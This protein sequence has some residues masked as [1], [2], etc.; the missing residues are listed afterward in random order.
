MSD[1][2]LDDALDAPETSSAPVFALRSQYIKDLSFESP[3]APASLFTTREAPN[4]EVTVNLAAQRLEAQAVEL[5]F[6]INVRA[7]ADKNTLFLV[8]LVYAG[9]LEIRNIADEA[10]EE[11]IFVRGAQQLFPFA[12]RVVADL[13]RDSGFPP[14]MLETMDFDAM[15]AAQKNRSVH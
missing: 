14:V 5:A 1:V 8:D 13:T 7:I 3:R 4:V 10:L 15:Y 11:A 9:I 2:D 6:H 12:R